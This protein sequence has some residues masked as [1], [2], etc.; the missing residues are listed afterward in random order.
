MLG[1]SQSSLMMAMPSSLSINTTDSQ[2]GSE[3]LH[4]LWQAHCRKDATSAA[5]FPT[6]RLNEGVGPL[7]QP[8]ILSQSPAE[9]VKAAVSAAAPRLSSL[10]PLK[11]PEEL[12]WGLR[13]E[14]S[15]DDSSAC[16]AIL[17]DEAAWKEVA[18]K[19]KEVKDV[20][21]WPM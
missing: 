13:V 9:E 5:H 14:Y 7:L 6:V 20:D 19:V 12:H 2:S 8:F 18:S 10:P 4:Q 21:A 3:L 17:K 11:G 1:P 15:N 16:V